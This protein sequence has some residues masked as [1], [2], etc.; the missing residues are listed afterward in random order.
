MYQVRGKVTLNG[1]SLPSGN[2][3]FVPK[4]RSNGPEPGE[5]KDGEYEL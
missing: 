2:I 5:I 3:L 1:E 4:D